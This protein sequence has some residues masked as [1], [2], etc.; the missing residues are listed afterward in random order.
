MS[1]QELDLLDPTQAVRAPVLLQ[2]SDGKEISSWVW[3]ILFLLVAV[4]AGVALGL[5]IFNTVKLEG[6]PAEIEN[7]IASAAALV[8]QMIMSNVTSTAEAQAG[9][10][11]AVLDQFQTALAE[12][13]ARLSALEGSPATTNSPPERRRTATRKLVY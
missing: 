13:D 2:S 7:E 4:M 10:L 6:A 3:T 12:L 9:A 1:D 11:L 5:S 8:S